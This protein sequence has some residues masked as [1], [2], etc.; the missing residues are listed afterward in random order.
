[1]VT[2]KQKPRVAAEKI[3]RKEYKYTTKE[4][5]QTTKKELKRR[6]KEKGITKLSENSQQNDSKFIPI[7]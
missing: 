4:S 1:M 6:R 5:H 7:L 2:T 3:M